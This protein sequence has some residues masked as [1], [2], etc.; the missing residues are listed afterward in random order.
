MKTALIIVGE[1]RSFSICKKQIINQIK[2]NN[3]DVFMALT[4]YKSQKIDT[5]D[6]PNLKYIKIHTHD[7]ITQLV[8]KTAPSELINK[9]KMEIAAKTN[10]KKY[11]PSSRPLNVFNSMIKFPGTKPFVNHYVQILLY[12]QAILNVEKANIY[13]HVIKMRP[14]ISFDFII[15]V[16][17]IFNPSFDFFC[18]VIKSYETVFNELTSKL[19][20]LLFLFL[21]YKDDMSEISKFFWDF[22][23]YSF[24][25]TI[26]N[27]KTTD[28]VKLN[29]DCLNPMI[30]NFSGGAP[31]F[32]GW[33]F[34]PNAH[35][36]TKTII[37]NIGDILTKYNAHKTV[38]LF[39]N[40]LFTDLTKLNE[41]IV[42]MYHDFI[43]ISTIDIALNKYV[44]YGK[45]YFDSQYYCDMPYGYCI[46]N[47]IH[48][49]LFLEGC[50]PLYLKKQVMINRC[51]L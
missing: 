16:N 45:D 44:R 51:I 29:D 18:N 2:I 5:S 17:T 28:L 13:T 36:I 24:T 40:N 1:I 19:P 38:D 22:C 32:M 47:I 11:K 7:D 31:I 8:S 34:N 41:K 37:N 30:Y 33:M 27:K 4:N 12:N 14:D 49:K 25:T 48:S 43:F 15:D 9:Y 42:Y 21:V 50:Y 26:M 35:V 20:E 3:C 23:D 10:L 39:N 6:I 46:E